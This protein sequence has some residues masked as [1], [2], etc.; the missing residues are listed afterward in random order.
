MKIKWVIIFYFL[1]NNFVFTQIN[2]FK[3]NSYNYNFNDSLNSGISQKSPS[4]AV[5]M[6]SVLPGLGQFYNESYWKIPIIYGLGAFFVYE[7]KDY[8]KKFN[9]FN[10]KFEASKTVDNPSGSYYLKSYREYYRDKR[11][12]FLWYG[13]FLYLLNILDAFVDA[14]LYN[15]NVSDEVFIQLKS[16]NNF[17]CIKILF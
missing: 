13:G 8:N 4:K 2:F 17:F 10:S 16:D 15:F 11:D 9:D 3:E 7:Y 1:L 12:A 14:H 6:S 5:I